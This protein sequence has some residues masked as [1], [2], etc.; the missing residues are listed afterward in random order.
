MLM[1]ILSGALPCWASTR[2]C[3]KKPSFSMLVL[4]RA[5]MARLKGSPSPKSSSRRITKSRVL[6]LP[7]MSMRST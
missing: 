2:T 7:V 5:T 4:P 3:E 6:S 1:M